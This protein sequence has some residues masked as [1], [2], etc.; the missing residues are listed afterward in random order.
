M[1]KKMKKFFLPHEE[2]LYKCYHAMKTRCLNPR[3]AN[4]YRYG[5]RGITVCEEW[6]KGFEIFYDWAISNGYADNLTLDR[7][8]NDSGY[9][10]ENCRWITIR[11]QMRNTSRNIYIE[12]TGITRPLSDYSELFHIPQYVLRQ[13][14]NNG[15]RGEVLFRPHKGRSRKVLCVEKGI[16]FNSITEAEQYFGL[17]HGGIWQVLKGNNKTAGGCTWRRVANE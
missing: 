10:P 1:G 9:S 12:H 8:N 4:Y 7:I 2:R 11:Q 13:R 17:K 6:L 15:E 14:F 16:V 5:G 3:D